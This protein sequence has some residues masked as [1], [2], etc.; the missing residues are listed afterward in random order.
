MTAP[1]TQHDLATA[2]L[3]LAL[4]QMATPATRAEGLQIVAKQFSRRQDTAEQRQAFLSD[5]L[6]G[7]ALWQSRT[8]EVSAA[9][10]AEQHRSDT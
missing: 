1:L 8:A 2:R 7:L 5:V 9:L 10:A 4:G 6:R 3:A